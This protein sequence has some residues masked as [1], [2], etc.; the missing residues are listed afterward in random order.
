MPFTALS[1]TNSRSLPKLMTIKSVM[2]S[3]DLILYC[4]LLLLPS[5]FSNIKVFSNDSALHSRWPKNGSF[6][7]SISP[8]SEYSGLVSFR[9]DWFDL[10]AA[11]EI[12]KSLLQHHNSKVSILQHSGF[13]M[14]QLSHSYMTKGKT[15]ALTI[16]IFASKVMS[17]LFNT[18][19]LLI[20]WLQSPSVVILDPKKRKSVTAST[21]SPSIC[22]EVLG[23]DTV[24]L[25]FWVF[26]K[27][28]V[29]SWLFHFRP[30]SRGSLV[31]RR[32]LPLNGIIHISE[33]V[34]F[35]GNLD[36]SLWLSQS[37]ISHG[38]LCI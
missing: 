5:I 37:G 16:Q 3:N 32:F 18:Y 10:L 19:H 27:Y 20:S 8:S 26:F 29:L 14:V 38:A 33:V 23:P 22:H 1:I 17:L 2:P 35:P 36:F 21:F 11:Q 31:P 34:I 30:P 28:C 13:F 6:G 4:S 15:I 24:I 9:F 25:G 12:L 7:F